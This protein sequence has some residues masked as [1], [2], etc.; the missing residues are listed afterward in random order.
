MF[1]WSYYNEEEGHE[2]DLKLE[3]IYKYIL[4]SNIFSGILFYFTVIPGLFV[5]TGVPAIAVFGLFAFTIGFIVQTVFQIKTC[6]KAIKRNA[7]IESLRKEIKKVYT[8]VK[9]FTILLSGSI[10]YD[11]EELLK[12]F[13]SEDFTQN[14]TSNKSYDYEK[15]QKN[16]NKNS[17]IEHIFNKYSLSPD[18]DEK[19]IRKQFRLLAKE[20]HPDMPTGDARKFMNLKEDIEYLIE[21]IKT[22]DKS[23]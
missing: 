22:Q 10:L 13:F 15:N 12:E 18:S 23:A 1:F 5:V 16:D 21:Y 14:Q 2:R 7:G 20:Y 8:F 9:D 19:T 17:K 3:Q 4:V 11:L 6:Y